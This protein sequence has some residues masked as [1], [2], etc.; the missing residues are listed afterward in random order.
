MLAAAASQPACAA[1]AYYGAPSGAL[2]GA[3][4]AADAA[5]PAAASLGISGAD[6]AASGSG[7][8]WG[9]AA[10][11]ADAESG[12]FDAPAAAE[13]ALE[14]MSGA[15]DAPPA[16]EDSELAPVTMSGA[17]DA[18]ETVAA[19]LATMSGAFDASEDRGAAAAKATQAALWPSSSQWRRWHA[20]PQY[21]ASLQRT[22]FFAP[23]SQQ[24]MQICGGAAPR[25][26]SSDATAK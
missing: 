19:V 24:T 2:E 23:L 25:D 15:F 6:R 3:R 17:L 11:G 14:T 7:Q 26:R 20:A 10:S 4:N 21:V 13:A 8:P 18:G 9:G 5:A 22:H 16:A 1:A 12:A